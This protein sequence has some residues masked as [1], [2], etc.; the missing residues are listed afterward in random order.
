MAQYKPSDEDI[1]VVNR[2]QYAMVDGMLGRYHPKAGDVCWASETNLT[3]QG[4]VAQRARCWAPSSPSNSP[5]RGSKP[6]GSPVLEF[7]LP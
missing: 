1:K 4:G 5:A 3:T 7:H 2:G 6:C